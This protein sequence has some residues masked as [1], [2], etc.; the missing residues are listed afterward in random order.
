MTL[1]Y[2]VYYVP[3]TIIAQLKA[4]YRKTSAGRTFARLMDL[5][6]DNEGVKSDSNTAGHHDSKVDHGVAIM[7]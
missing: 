4:H 3:K 6:V 1:F 2:L 7:E 5:L